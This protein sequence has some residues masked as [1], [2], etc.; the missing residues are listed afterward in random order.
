MTGQPAPT[1]TPDGAAADH[2]DGPD[3]EGLAVVE[4][5]DTIVWPAR[6]VLPSGDV[7]DGAKVWIR[8]GR[9]MVYAERGRQPYRRYEGAITGAVGSHTLSHASNRHR[10]VTLDVYGARLVVEGTSGCGCHS[11][12]AH[13]TPPGL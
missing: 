7:V 5:P 11:Q 4:V 13:Y 9:V 1:G 3:G 2:V 8:A 12:L 6:V 10:K